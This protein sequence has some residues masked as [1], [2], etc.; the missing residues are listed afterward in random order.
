MF[1]VFMQLDELF[2]ANLRAE[3]D[4]LD[5]HIG[6]VVSAGMLTWMH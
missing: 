4:P 5:L 1:A 6:G 3:A 2:G